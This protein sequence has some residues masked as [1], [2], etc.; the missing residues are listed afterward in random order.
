MESNGTIESA[1]RTIRLSVI[2][3]T[4]GFCVLLFWGIQ[5]VFHLSSPSD[6]ELETKTFKSFNVNKTAAITPQRPDIKP[7]ALPPETTETSSA[8]AQSPAPTTR[9][10]QSEPASNLPSAPTPAV[11]PALRQNEGGEGS[12]GVNSIYGK[13]I[14]DGT[15]P[16]ETKLPLDPTCGRLNAGSTPTTQFYRVA[17]NGGL[18]DVFV[19][20]SDGLSPKKYTPPTQPLIIDQAGCFYAPYVAG[21]MTGQTI[22]VLNSDPVLHNVHPTPAVQGNQ[23]YNKAH[24]P[25]SA[26]LLFRWSKPE[27]FLRFKCDVHPWMFAYVSLL[28]HPF[29]AVTDAEGK[30]N[31][32][33]VPPGKY[34]VTLTHRKA[35]STGFEVTVIQGKNVSLEAKLQPAQ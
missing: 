13:V 4:L 35:G 18:A 31:I 7:P 11:P 27:L 33:N 34:V 8:S 6:Q 26:P 10:A 9:P 1:G 16:P 17:G 32:P 22:E 14:L 24:L 3:V 5:K 29:F 21:A 28:D 12:K 30:F 23:E 15:P 25:N 19:Y 2:L 20:I